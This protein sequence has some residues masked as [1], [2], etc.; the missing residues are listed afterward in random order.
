MSAFR[1]LHWAQCAKTGGP[2]GKVVLL[3]LAA[4]ADEKGTCFP[5]QQLIARETEL[6]LRAVQTW[7][8]KLEDA[9]LISRIRGKK[10]DGTWGLTRYRLNLDQSASETADEPHADSACGTQDVVAPHANSAPGDHTQMTASPHANDDVTTRN[11][12]GS[13]QP[14]EL[15]IELT[16][17]DS[18]RCVGHVQDMGEPQDVDPPDKPKPERWRVVANQVLQVMGRDWNDPRWTGTVG[19]VNQWL[20]N[21]WDPDLDILPTVGRVVDRSTSPIHSLGYFTNAIEQAYAR[22]K[23]AER[24]PDNPPAPLPEPKFV[25]ESALQAERINSAIDDVF[26]DDDG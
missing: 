13:E 23:A 7:L 10:K 18:A 5:S 19:I 21:G 2:S 14:R 3:L 15:P 1:A 12:C 26:G 4:Y 6:S 8:K 17:D 16:D 25:D 9:G 22:R 20:A 11:W 24:D